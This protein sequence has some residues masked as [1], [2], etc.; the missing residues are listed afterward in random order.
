LVSLIHFPAVTQ[1][2]EKRQL[3][4]ITII[5]CQGFLHKIKEQ[6]K[7][8]S[9]PA[10][11]LAVFP[12]FVLLLIFAG[13]G[14]T[15]VASEQEEEF[16]APLDTL[17]QGESRSRITPVLR[18]EKKE[19]LES[20]LGIGWL[21][22]EKID[23][24]PPFG[25]TIE[26]LNDSILVV[27]EDMRLLQTFLEA[28]TIDPKNFY[29]SKVKMWV[30]NNEAIRDSLFFA[31]LAVDSSL[32]SEYGADAEILATEEDDLVQARFGTAVFKGA[33][34]KEAIDKSHDRFLYQKIVQS[35]RYSKDIEL[36][37]T[38][39]RL[40]TPF[41]T[42]LLDHQKTIE[43][44]S[45]LAVRTNPEPRRTLVEASLCGI[46]A[47]IGPDWG[48]EVR[49]GN[50]EIGLPFWSSGKMSFFALY[51]RIRFGFELPI[52]FGKDAVDIFSTFSVPKRLLS[53]TRGLAGEFDFGSVGGYLS[54][55]KISNSDISSFPDPNKFFY[56]TSILHGYYSLS[57]ST[58]FA[59]YVRVKAGVSHYQV[60]QGHVARV[61]S[62]QG[63]TQEI[64]E[65]DQMTYLSPY[66][67]FEYVNDSYDE[68]YGGSVQYND[69]VLM[70][71]AWINIVP[72]VF[73]L[74][75]KYARPLTRDL[76]EWQS[77][78]F[79]MVSPKVHI[80]F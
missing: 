2:Q 47:R 67:Q 74:E 46:G 35:R 26:A 52:P 36:R 50:D 37:D 68:Q 49:F 11:L 1:F 55:T 18:E 31:L 28:S 40:A 75:L 45:P 22:E 80:A 32:A 4:A 61:V 43:L 57:F 69:F 56:I 71:R 78:S 14:S 77:A 15:K 5:N 10:F 17:P 60:K 65:D 39:F 72:N 19:G 70:V 30:I 54:L 42:E 63:T 27:N 51:K 58:G 8:F 76:R 59:Q 34:L 21:Q 16:F 44:F 6:G 29:H 23:T 33:I 25:T 38:S 3:E 41:Q 79:V 7:E 66:L 20:E 64:R 73:G 12:F 53:G 13:C 9:F 48:G 24:V 62:A